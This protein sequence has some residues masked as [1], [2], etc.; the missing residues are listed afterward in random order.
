[1]GTACVKRILVLEPTLVSVASQVHGCREQLSGRKV[2]PMN[3]V[4]WIRDG[5]RKPGKSQKGLAGA[6]GVVPSVVSK[7]LNGRREIKAAEISV[8]ALYL[9]SSPPENA[10]ARL[11]PL[12]PLR[13][14]PVRAKAELGVWR[15]KGRG[16]MDTTLVPASP[17][18]RVL[19]HDQYAV[20]LEGLEY[21]GMPG[22]YAICVPW[23]V[24]RAEPRDGDTVHVQLAQ[25]DLVQDLVL[26]FVNGRLHMP[27]P[28]A[29]MVPSIRWDDPQVT[30]AGLVIGFY[31][32][33]T[34]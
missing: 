14:I 6:L 1:M 27:G 20:V 7:I 18:P 29:N 31:Q 16:V 22:R 8:I 24:I 25:G 23:T 30:L 9:E 33:T 26:T 34:F 32:P 11:Q 15:A 13:T 4:E 2:P 17:D 5:L 10:P 28:Y 19:N 21:D 3:Y 12:I